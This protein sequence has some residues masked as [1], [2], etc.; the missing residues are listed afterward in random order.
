MSVRSQC[1]RTLQSAPV[2]TWFYRPHLPSPAYPS[3]VGGLLVV[4]AEGVDR[5]FDVVSDG[6]GCRADRPIIVNGW[7]VGE[8]VRGAAVRTIRYR[9]G[10][11]SDGGWPHAALLRQALEGTDLPPFAPAP[12]RWRSTGDFAANDPAG[13]EEHMAAQADA[14]GTGK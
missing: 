3:G 5:F 13:F 6:P 8:R 12:S 1:H 11:E 7:Q 9:P 4:T 14:D 2:A 10:E